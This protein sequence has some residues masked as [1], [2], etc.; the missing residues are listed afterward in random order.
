MIGKVLLGLFL[1]GALTANAGASI[2][3]DN[4]TCSNS[5]TGRTCSPTTA[6]VT[7]PGAEFMLGS[8]LEVDI[9]ASSIIISQV[10]GTFGIPSS[11]ILTIGDINQ[12]IITGVTLGTVNNL[13]NPPT[14][15]SLSFTSDSVIIDIASGTWGP[16]SSFEVLIQT[17]AVPVPSAVLLFGSGLLGLI[18]I[19][20]RKKAA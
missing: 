16:G 11:E 2:V 14:Q 12:V 1:G 10:A 19:S 5:F 18:G 15:G 20:R 6:V 3:G 8:Q 17:S 9:F 7:D 13:V 4:V